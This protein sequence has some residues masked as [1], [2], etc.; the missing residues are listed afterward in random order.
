MAKNP[1][2]VRTH[3]GNLHGMY[4]LG[5]RILTPVVHL[6]SRPRWD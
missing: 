4:W 6:L 1:T 3:R 2:Q 5:Y